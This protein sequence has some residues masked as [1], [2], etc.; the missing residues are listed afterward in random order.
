MKL[1]LILLVLS[2]LAIFSATTGGYFYY[3]SLKKYALQ[4]AESQAEA[5]LEIIKRNIS[6]FLS[7]NVRPVRTLAGI[8]EMGKVL[9]NSASNG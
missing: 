5:R 4:E 2:L 3:A 6:S 8:D 7:E 1:R 9:E